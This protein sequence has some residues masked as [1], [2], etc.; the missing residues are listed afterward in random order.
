V[1]PAEAE[2]LKRGFMV[3]TYYN[4]GAGHPSYFFIL[5]F[6]KFVTNIN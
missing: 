3:L 6:K 5:V 1:S 2:E 4:L